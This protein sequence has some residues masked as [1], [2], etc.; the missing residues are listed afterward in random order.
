MFVLR[1]WG[2]APWANG[3]ALAAGGV[4]G[5]AGA[6]VAPS[7]G[8]RLGAGPAI[9]IGCALA[10]VPWLALAVAPVNAASSLGVLV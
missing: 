1:E 3:V 10:V 7:V 6:L 2:L 5:F 9:L 4:G 8:A